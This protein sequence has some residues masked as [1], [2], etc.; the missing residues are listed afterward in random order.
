MIRRN[1]GMV[2]V[3]TIFAGAWTNQSSAIVI[4]GQLDAAYGAA[5]AT[6][7]YD[8]FAPINNYQTPGP[9]TNNV[10]YSLYNVDIAGTYYG[11]L[12]ASGPT[13]TLS[14]ANVYFDIDPQN[15]NGSDIG[16]EVTNS[17]A[18]V[19]GGPPGEYAPLNMSNYGFS[20]AVSA[21]GTGIEF[22]VSNSL[23][24]G[25]I[26]GLTYFPGQAFASDGSDVVL[27]LSQSFGYS[28]AGG[29]TYGDDRLG[30]VTLAAA[31]TTVPE[32]TSL[33]LA[34]LGLFAL[35]LSRRGRGVVLN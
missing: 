29:A 18:F 32:P 16:I 34:G 20:Y 6:V 22:E 1:M 15:G 25:A 13:N 30:R 2:Y 17:R 33:A 27:R 35:V 8:S 31:A 28:V 26:P 21:D 24:E 12:K 5:K 11:F 4:D 14:F 7:A 23:F 19:A 9:T 3:A 10:A